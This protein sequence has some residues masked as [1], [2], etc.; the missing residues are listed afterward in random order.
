MLAQINLLA[1]N[2]K[3]MQKVKRQQ[4][5][6]SIV[7]AYNKIVNKNRLVCACKAILGK[8][9]LCSKQIFKNSKIMKIY[10]L[11]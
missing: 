11:R 9:K 6:I 3:S 5:R 10:I 1:K 8:Y 4:E 7:M 2:K